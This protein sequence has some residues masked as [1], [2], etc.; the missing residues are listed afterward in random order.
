MAAYLET[1]AQFLDNRVVEFA[2][3]MPLSMKVSGGRG[4]VLLRQLLYRHVPRAL[5]DRPKMGFSIPL[6]EWLRG[7]LRDW[8]EAL[9]A[10]DRLRSEGFLDPVPIRI[11]WAQH[12]RGDASFGYRLWSVLMFQAWLEDTRREIQC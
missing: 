3:R 9:L 2:W 7:P 6:D 4:K 11:V 5:M 1:R 10:E 12:L 8:A